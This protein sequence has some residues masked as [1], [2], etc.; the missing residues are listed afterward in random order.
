MVSAALLAAV[1]DAYV[2]STGRTVLLIGA[3]VLGMAL[4][5][6]RADQATFEADRDRSALPFGGRIN[7]VVAVRALV[8]V[9]AVVGG[10]LVGTLGALAFGAMVVVGYRLTAD[11]RMARRRSQFEDQ[12]PEMLQMVAGSLRSGTS[13]LQSLEVVRQEAPQPLSSE[14]RRVL[15]EGR[16]GRDLNDSFSDLATRMRS[17][18]FEWVVGAFDIHREVGGDL[19]EVLDRISDTIRG[20]NRVRGQMQALSAEGRLSGLVLSLLPP[21]MFLALS[22]LNPTYISELTDRGIGWVLLGGATALL[23]VGAIWLQRMARFDF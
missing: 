17:T 18:D 6:P 15:H 1:G 3:C 5:L 23:V 8:V 20:R 10:L 16:L 14:I 19:A 21:G 11:L 22:V 13:L 7:L 9:A 12:L 4:I 2:G